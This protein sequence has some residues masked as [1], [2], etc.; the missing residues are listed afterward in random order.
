MELQLES[1]IEEQQDVGPRVLIVEDDPETAELIQD[2]L[3]RSLD[4]KAVIASSGQEALEL[5][6]AQS[7][8]VV[9]VDYMLP[10]GDGLALM[11][12]INARQARPMIMITGHA[13]LGRA[14][15]AM[16]FGAVDMF[17]K[18][19]DLGRLG[20]SV[21]KA[22]QEQLQEHRKTG[23]INRVRRLSRGVIRER[24]EMRRKMD[25]LCRDLVGAY[26][27]LARKVC[28]RQCGQDPDPFT[29]EDYLTDG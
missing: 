13:T 4:C 19:F 15:Q 21:S 5:D 1:Q 10:D 24:R 16:R 11:K 2:Y 17:L 3:N 20:R 14:M 28:A 9:L 12:K 7:A 8:H 23:R 26:E 29:A 22:L 18:P 25:L 6:Q 27:Q